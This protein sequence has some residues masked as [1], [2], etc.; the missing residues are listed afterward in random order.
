M[1]I[2]T[3]ST[4]STAKRALKS[5]GEFAVA[6][7]DRLIKE[8]DGSFQ[9]DATEAE[10]VQVYETTPVIDGF[11]RCPSC[12][13][14][15]SNGVGHHNQDV[16][17]T[18]VKHEKYV[19]ACLGCGAEFGPAIHGKKAKAASGKTRVVGGTSTTSRPCKTVWNIADD[20]FKANP[21]VTRKEVVAACVQ[22][23]VTEGTAKTQYQH[24]YAVAR[25]G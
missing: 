15:L 12:G 13:A 6:A 7:A 22:A 21:S 14:H 1:T 16:N 18:L 17:G 24:W 5:F 10:L 19:Y 8:V 23:G 2:K 11:V 4:K 20:M 3:Y 9:F 25:R